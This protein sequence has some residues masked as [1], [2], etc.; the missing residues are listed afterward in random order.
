[1]KKERKI[2]ALKEFM[3]GRIIEVTFATRFEK[4]EAII[5]YLTYFNY[6]YKVSFYLD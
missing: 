5:W 3:V 1:M 4:H 6:T 2:E